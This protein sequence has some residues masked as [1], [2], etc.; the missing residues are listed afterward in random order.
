MNFKINAK[1]CK[2]SVIIPSWNGKNLLKD[3]LPSLRKQIFKSFEVI[4]IDN[5]STDGTVSYVEKNYPDVK[6]IKLDSNSGFAHAVNLGIKICI[7]EHI[8][9]INNDTRVDVN[10]LQFLVKAAQKKKNVGII[11]AKMLKF[12]NPKL[13]DSA[14]DWID[15]VGHAS[16]IGIGQ[17]DSRKF[18]NPGYIFLAT[19]GGSLIK[20]EV[21]EKIGFF[22]ENYFAYMEDVDFCLRAQMQGIKCWY[23]P[24]AVIY[25]KHK[26]TSNKF[27]PFAEY[28]QF[29][30]MTQTIIKDFPSKLLF[31]DLNFL[32]II[33]VNLNTVLYFIKLGLWKEAV[34]AEGFIIY[35]LFRLLRERRK[36]QSNIKV[37]IDFLINNFRP[38]KITFYKFLKTGI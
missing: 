35:H 19:G 28:L 7:G 18:N 14:G 11:A 25:H 27:K 21:F 36:I 16:N 37:D 31:K 15:T 9:L 34:K 22:D 23:E 30:N 26:A 3:C 8:I 29:R 10:C 20:R 32:K 5:G 13:I 33:L 4:V 1:T 6:L 24:R 17:K 2:A 12:N 38:K